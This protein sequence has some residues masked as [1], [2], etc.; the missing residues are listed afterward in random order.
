M[1]KLF[2]LLIIVFVLGFCSNV[3][4]LDLA[5][6][7]GFTSKGGVG[8]P[9]GELADANAF[10]A[11]MGYGFGATGEFFLTDRVALG[12]HFDYMSFGVTEEDVDYSLKL[13]SFGAFVKYIFPTNTNIAP[14][15][16]TSTG[17]YEPKVSGSSDGT[18]PSASFDM[19]F[20]FGVGAGV[21]FKASDFVV[22]GA[23]AVFHDVMS[24]ETEELGCDL[25]Y[26]Q[27]NAGVTLL[28]GGK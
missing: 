4:A 24:Q 27:I 28:V 1:K 20:G 23:E 8:K 26:I 2:G 22:I 15:L 25:Q 21:M 13:T 7:F 3:L 6:K 11:D 17:M 16:K 19:K 18:I 5:G 12:G 14:Y 9:M 10:G